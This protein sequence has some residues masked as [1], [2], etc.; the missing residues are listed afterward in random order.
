MIIVNQ[1]KYTEIDELKAC[2]ISS[3][4]SMN[5]SIKIS[6]KLGRPR[7]HRETHSEMVLL[8]QTDK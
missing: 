1:H 7:F 2:A 6:V 3:A 5:T 4:P 8:E